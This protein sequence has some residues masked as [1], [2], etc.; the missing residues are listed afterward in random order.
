MEHF[1]TMLL[2]AAVLILLGL[3]CVIAAIRMKKTGKISSLIASSEEAAKCKKTRD[4][5]EEMYLPFLGMGI[6]CILFGGFSIIDK[7]Y[8][9]FPVVVRLFASLIFFG[10]CA[11]VISRQRKVRRKYLNL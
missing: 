2:V 11:T 8:Y 9:A 7:C 1:E 4:L 6:I 10:T 5:I 3:Y